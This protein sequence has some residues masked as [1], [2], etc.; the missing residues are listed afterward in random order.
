MQ[1]NQKK[2][3]LIL[4]F[5]LLLFPLLS[6]GATLYFSP[7]KAEYGQGDVFKVEVRLD[8]KGDSINACEA[9]IYFDKNQLE[10]ADIAKGGSLTTLWAK[11]PFYSNIEGTIVLVGG[12]PGGFK[13]DG[14]IISIIFRAVGSGPAGVS[15]Q[16]GSRVLLNDGKGTPA[17]LVKEDAIFE[18]SSS[19]A[20]P[21]DEWKKEIEKDKALPE[22]FEIKIGQ[23]PAVY[24]GRY[25]I[26]FSTTDKQ[27]GIAYYQIKEGGSDWKT[28]ES[29]YLL[30]DQGLEEK[31]LV[32][33]VD[34]AGNERIE[35]FSASGSSF[36]Y[37]GLLT[38][39]IIIFWFIY[40]FFKKFKFKK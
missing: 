26:V 30:N 4:F 16:D 34:K 5:S 12:I 3:F 32:K 35:E 19:K 33:A 11:D 15:F 24:E 6:N 40:L 7:E 2:Q 13:G 39:L 1:F 17:G 9:K 8:T 14:K 21:S 10:I 31:V 28:G 29:P 27:T 25:F 37:V 18:I 38:L 36:S 22:S 20:Q 23:D